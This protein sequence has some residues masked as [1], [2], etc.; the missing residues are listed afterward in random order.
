[1]KTSIRA[2]IMIFSAALLSVAVVLQLLFGV[3][4]SK[5]FFVHERE[6]QMLEL[7]E[8]LQSNYTDN[9][10]QLSSLTEK[11]ENTHNIKITVFDNSEVVYSTRVSMGGFEFFGQPLLF[12]N[13]PPSP[14]DIPP[15]GSPV[16]DNPIKKVPRIDFSEFSVNPEVRHIG[17][18]NSNL[19]LQGKIVFGNEERYI[20]LSSS[21]ESIDSSVAMFTKVNFYISAV[22]LLAGLVC[23]YFVA[24][25]INKP[26]KNIEAVSQKISKLDFEQTADETVNTPELSSLASSINTMSYRLSTAIEELKTANEKL[27][28]DIDARKRTEKTQRDFIANV[29]HEM[30]TPLCLL[31][32]YGEN[33]KNDVEGIDKEYYCQTIID[34]TERLNDMVK[35]MLEI[36]SIEN[37]LHSIKKEK[38]NFSELCRYTV[39]KMDIVL[40]HA[41]CEID[42]TE[43][44]FVN[45]DEKYLEQAIK[46]YLSNAATHTKA[47][48][49]IEIKLCEEDSCAV[50]TVFNEGAVID[51]QKLPFI[52]DRF[53]RTDEARVRT[54]ALHAGLGLSIVKSVVG[55]HGGNC[56]AE[57]TDNGVKFT[58]VIPL[59]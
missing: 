28:A 47:G 51:P 52:W 45:G 23:A 3:F 59:A 4:L 34:E 53:Y 27:S 39:N 15:G 12:G 32:M 36:S 21:V 43:N 25:S 57:N 41:E 17:A 24:K 54:E 22:I 42:I 20:F 48:G 7:F 38:L 26:I 30:K 11:S 16:G 8:T 40:Q 10:L 14:N 2:K 56:T 58:F 29:S 9:T 44:L 6:K 19:V 49:K 55:K 13:N 50:F 37:E 33:L 1:M 31:Q 46:N 18:E 5:T 35:T